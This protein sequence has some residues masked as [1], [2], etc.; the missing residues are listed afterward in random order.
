MIGKPE[1]KGPLRRPRSEWEYNIEMELNE[2]GWGCGLHS[3][4]SGYGPVVGCCGH[5]DEPFSFHKMLG[6]S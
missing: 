1:G 4:S 6:I 3:F 2:T 5:G